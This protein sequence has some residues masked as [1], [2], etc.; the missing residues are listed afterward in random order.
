[1]AILV[2]RPATSKRAAFD[3]PPGA[4]DFNALRLGLAAPPSSAIYD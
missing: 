2:Q 1:V 3:F 4:F